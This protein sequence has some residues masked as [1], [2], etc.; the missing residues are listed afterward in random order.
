MPNFKVF[1][2]RNVETDLSTHKDGNRQVNSQRTVVQGPSTVQWQTRRD[3]DHFTLF[4]QFPQ[5]GRYHFN[6]ELDSRTRFRT[7]WNGGAA[8]IPGL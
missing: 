4:G 7:G 8:A 5:G 6:P 2:V 1:P 3:V